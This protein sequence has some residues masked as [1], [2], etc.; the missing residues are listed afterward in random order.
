MASGYL[1]NPGGVM[2]SADVQ[3][4]GVDAWTRT[5]GI[6]PTS[7]LVGGPGDPTD[8]WHLPYNVDRGRGRIVTNDAPTGPV[9]G[10]GVGLLDDWRDI[11]NWRHSPVP[12]LLIFTLAVVGLMQFRVMVRAG[13]R[14]GVSAGVGLG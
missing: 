3:G 13:G 12:W 14:K 1:Q 6:P 10:P 2:S 5:A 4:A 8:A 11:I 9:G 7:A